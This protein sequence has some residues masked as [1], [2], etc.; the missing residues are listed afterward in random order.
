[1]HTICIQI[2]LISIFLKLRWGKYLEVMELPEQ[3]TS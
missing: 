1:L 3:K 2:P